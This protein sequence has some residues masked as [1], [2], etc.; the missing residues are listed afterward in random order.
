MSQ[1][2]EK[3]FPVT[4]LGVASLMVA[5]TVG[6]TAL[7]FS[8]WFATPSPAA[9]EEG[10][11]RFQPRRIVTSGFISVQ[12]T[13]P[14]WAPTASL[15]EIARCWDRAGH[16][17]A[18]AI[19]QNMARNPP[20]DEQR[21]S[22]LI[23]KSTSY[24]YE[25]ETAQASRALEEARVLCENNRALAAEW[26]YTVIYCQGLASLRRGEDENC[27]MCRGES[28]CILPI[29]PAAVHTNP[30]GS[31]L[32][33]KYFTE[34]LRQF[35]DDF[36][37]RWLL[38]L[39]FMTL[40]E[41]PSTADAHLVI[42]LDRYN[43]SEFDIGRFRDIGHK[44]GVNRYNMAGGAILEDFDGDGLL[45]LIVSTMSATESMAYYRN[46][47]DGTFEDRTRQAGLTKLL[48]GLYCVQA[49]YNN[50][51]HVDVYV[52]RGAW[53]GLPMRPSLLRNNGN[54]TFTDVTEEA[55][56]LDPV[57]SNSASWADF[58]NDGHLD[59]FVSCERQPSRLFRNR[60]DGTFEDVTV[61]A[62]L[63]VD[64]QPC[65]GCA[66]VDFDNDGYPDVFLNNI[67][68]TGKLFRNNRNGTFTDVTDA[69]GIDGP[70][71]GFSC[72]AFDYDNDGWLDVF[73]TS[74]DRTLAAAVKGLLGLPHDRQSSRLYRNLQGKGFKDVTQEAGLDA[75]YATMGSNYADFD[76]DGYLDFYL[77]TGDPNLSTLL[78]NRM[79][80]NVA[81]QR[82]AEITASSGTGH[83]Q[84]GHA[85]TCGDWARDG[86][87][88]LF[89]QMGGAMPGDRYHNVLFRNPGNSNNWLTVKL[90]G[91]K[92]NRSA[93][94]ARIKV[95][96]AGEKPLTVHR[97]ISTGSS[98]GA[99]PLQQTLGLGKTDRVA[100]LEVYWPT[101]KNTQVFRD[102]AV[103]QAIEITEFADDYRK[104]DWK[105][106]PLPK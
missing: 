14:T 27:V 9:P 92:T 91:K 102:V 6:V 12:A 31:R 7:N 73:A 57:N 83:L 106:I 86:H 76:N 1:V 71:A 94:G 26:L 67:G 20:T 88:D 41:Q 30:Q 33:I 22:A 75:V 97:H 78:P 16:R 11:Q 36:E 40:G 64:A 101:S 56:L 23:T 39:A 28:S 55:G 38:T 21:L 66:W 43:K 68:G 77:A 25:G 59:L 99:N 44:V 104:L 84:K 98:F 54:G 2:A 8:G 19:D 72:W 50:D 61:K 85:V 62:G 105:P 69:M 5:L 13:V 82:F 24:H 52:P 29:A 48:G 34:Y 17:L 3:S 49:D 100:T 42:S 53:L 4:L 95:V 93:I 81:G 47:G 74:Y 96:T 37:V 45:D 35:P 60:G 90:V 32:A 46:K 18:E 63:R 79:F 103:N 89:V 80:K 58:D 10:A 65:K 70:R 87:V 15:E 51:G